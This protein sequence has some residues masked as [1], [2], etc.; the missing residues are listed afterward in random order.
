[1][2]PGPDQLPLMQHAL[3]RAWTVARARTPDAPPTVELRDYIEVGRL[4]DALSLHADTAY[5][6][7]R[8]NQKPIADRL[9]RA[10][11][12][13][14]TGKRD[15]RRP[16]SLGEVAAI[17]E[18][19]PEAVAA[20]VEHFRGGDLNFL[21][22]ATGELT[23]ETVLDISHESL[24]RQWVKLDT[25]AKDEAKS[26]ETYRLLERLAAEKKQPWTGSDLDGILKWRSREHPNRAWAAR[27]GGDF[28]A[29]MAFIEAGVERQRREEA[30]RAGGRPPRATLAP[31]KVL[32]S[33]ALVGVLVVGSLA[34]WALYERSKAARLAS[35]APSWQ[36]SAP[37]G[38]R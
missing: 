7:L 10:L 16:T 24:I 30:E 1:M 38:I 29:V 9:F 35:S 13:G 15:T 27:Y 31:F 21:T 2:G 3:M 8:E 20:V 37:V 34:A 33:A 36:Q 32:A 26:A 12:G 11:S 28:A 22:P 17:A 5:N 23:A 6:N 4:K 18:V 14:S 19:E 25:W